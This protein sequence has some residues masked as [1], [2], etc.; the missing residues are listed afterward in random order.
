LLTNI[1][2][3][4]KVRNKKAGAF[5]PREHRT[6]ANK[7][8]VLAAGNSCNVIIILKHLLLNLFLTDDF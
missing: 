6:G 4:K 1:S 2:A 3:V 7:Q 5:I 8:A